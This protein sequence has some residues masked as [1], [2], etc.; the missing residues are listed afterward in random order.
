MILMI[1]E[2]REWMF[3]IDYSKVDLIT[4][5]DGLY[6]Q[7]YYHDKFAELKI[8]MIYFISSDIIC[9]ANKKQSLEFPRCDIAHKEFFETGN[10]QHYMTL[11]QIKQLQSFGHEIGGHS[12][13]HNR[14]SKNLSLSDT[15]D[16]II[17]DTQ[18]MMSFFRKNGLNIKSFCFPYNE[19]FTLYR[20]ILKRHGINKFYGK[21][22]IAIE[23]YR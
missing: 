13:T 23:D 5:D 21:E 3:D 14:I 22:R 6:S 2:V 8:P 19:E 10:A 17:V 7:Y 11:D 1:H 4:F 9:P 12:H 16:H 15:Y 20:K 18:A